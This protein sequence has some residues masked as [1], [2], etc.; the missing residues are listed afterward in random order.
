MSLEI[1]TELKNFTDGYY[2][3]IETVLYDG[4]YAGQQRGVCF[5]S[6]DD[7]EG[8]FCT[9]IQ[10]EDTFDF[11]QKKH[12]F[13]YVNNPEVDED[14]YGHV[15]STGSCFD[16]QGFEIYCM[17]TIRGWN[18]RFDENENGF[19]NLSDYLE[20]AATCEG[21]SKGNDASVCQNFGPG[22][23]LYAKWYQPLVQNDTKSAYPRLSDGETLK[24]DCFDNFMKWNVTSVE[25]GSDATT[26][27]ADDVFDLGLFDFGFD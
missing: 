6:Q 21:S 1:P 4:L 15:D 26:E 10:A 19:Y 5:G 14:E 8:Q 25:V 16:D 27:G 11:V 9:Y 3:E 24:V 17:D 7:T 22:A 2:G 13:G 12:F 18:Q 20:P 23:S